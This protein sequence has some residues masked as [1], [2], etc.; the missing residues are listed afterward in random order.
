[1]QAAEIRN[2]LHLQVDQIQDETSLQLLEDVVQ[3]L[4]QTSSDPLPPS[5]VAG[6]QAG[7]EDVAAGRVIS[8]ADANDQID[9]WLA[10]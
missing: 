7:L 8:E 10:Q 9:K 1:M 2:L 5:V 3:N 4:L 6:I